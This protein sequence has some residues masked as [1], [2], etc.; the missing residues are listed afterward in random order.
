M[1]DGLALDVNFIANS[2]A[3]TSGRINTNLPNPTNFA[4]PERDRVKSEHVASYLN[5]LLDRPWAGWNRGRG[6]D[7]SGVS[8]LL[9]LF[10]IGPKQIRIGGKRPNGYEVGQFADAFSRYLVPKWSDGS[11]NGE[12][13]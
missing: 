3:D 7:A 13:D 9:E 6:I 10:D 4:Q 2:V 12:T 1:F 5:T 11:D 8:K